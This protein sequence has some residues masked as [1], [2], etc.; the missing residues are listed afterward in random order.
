MYRLDRQVTAANLFHS[1]GNLRG[2][3]D[4]GRERYVIAPVLFLT[5]AKVGEIGVSEKDLTTFIC[6]NLV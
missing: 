3:L 4:F 1:V 2:V 5:Q 6:H